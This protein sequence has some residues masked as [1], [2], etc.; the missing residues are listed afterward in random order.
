MDTVDSIVKTLIVGRNYQKVDE[1]SISASLFFD[2]QEYMQSNYPLIDL[3]LLE[4]EMITDRQIS[5]LANQLHYAKAD[6]DIALLQRVMQLL[7]EFSGQPSYTADA[8]GVNL[9]NVQ[10]EYIK[11]QD[12]IV[13]VTRE[14]ELP[15]PGSPPY[16]GLNY[17]DIDDADLFFG[18]EKLIAAFVDHLRHHSFL[19]VI[20]A[21]GSGKSSIIRAGLVPALMHQRV[22]EDGT[23]PPNGSEMWPVLMLTPTD[24]PLHNLAD[25]LI[26][27]LNLNVKKNILVAEMLSDPTILR[28]Y[29]QMA[30][31][32]RNKT[33]EP[34]QTHRILIVID[35]F[36]EL[37]T[38]LRS[39]NNQTQTQTQQIR[40]AYINNLL[41]A[42]QVPPSECEEQ[43]SHAI[44]VITLR[45]DFYA[46]C[47]EFDNL[48]EALE[49][50]QKYIGS[51]NLDE[52]RHAIE[53]PLQMNGWTIQPELVDQL[54]YDVGDEPGALPLLSHALLETWKRRSGRTLTFAGYLAT[55]RVQGAIAKTAENV[56]AKE[57]TAQQQTLARNIFLRLTELGEGVEYTRRRAN[58]DELIPKTTVKSDVEDVIDILTKARLITTSSCE[59][60]GQIGE[61]ID[62]NAARE[63]QVEVSHE[64]LIREWPSLHSWLDDNQGKLRV[65]RHVTEATEQWINR[66]KDSSV[67]FRGAR[68]S[69]A[70][71]LIKENSNVLT[72]LEFKFL[73]A[74]KRLMWRNWIIFAATIIAATAVITLGITGQFNKWIYR[75]LPSERVNIPEGEFWMGTSDQEVEIIQQVY[76][77]Y[78]RPSGNRELLHLVYLDGYLIDKFEVTNKRYYQC[79]RA[80]QCMPPSNGKYNLGEYADFPVTHVNWSQAEQFCAW[81]DGRLPTEAEWEKAAKGGLYP[82]SNA[83]NEKKANVKGD[84]DQI[85]DLNPVGSYEGLP[86]KATDMAGN[87]WEWVADWF[88]IDYYENSPYRNPTGPLEEPEVGYRTVRG[89]SFKDN[90][91][92]ARSAHRSA[93]PPY[94][95]DEDLGF[96]CVYPEPS[97]W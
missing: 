15:T 64:A 88:D 95:S 11:I 86:G 21:S 89:G 48:R 79:V 14:K 58:L 57:L 40:R 26:W 94:T 81:D 43:E 13:N 12:V 84:D 69:E 66:G 46:H 5:N 47:A 70:M 42:I 3:T 82:W 16:K 33:N 9:Q 91:V 55:G 10:A 23:L 97:G 59:N 61:R 60:N 34:Q 36:E 75:P 78:F 22:L 52:L 62:E 76:P 1:T 83:P 51:M 28:H 7:Q 63:I 29:V 54:L 73:L 24:R 35:Q 20:G 8:I 31:N 2:L 93:Y 27:K 4:H 71:D 6:Q 45:A 56:Y 38:Q 77:D 49:R 53:D 74:S 19:A 92:K 87:V 39:D 65:H 96:R 32:S 17:F 41:T 85:G 30:L 44:V 37:F 90:W 72:E 68:L 25:H 80:N 50:Q 18:R 67:L